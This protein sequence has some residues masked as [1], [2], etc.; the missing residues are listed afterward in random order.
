MDDVEAVTFVDLV[1]GHD[2][3]FAVDL[4]ERDRDH[5]GAGKVEG[6][7]FVRG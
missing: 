4:E 2:A 1:A 5:Q 3:V 6:V 7:V